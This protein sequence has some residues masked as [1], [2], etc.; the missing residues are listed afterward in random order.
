MI[1]ISS[2]TDPYQ[3]LEERN[4]VTRRSLEVLLKMGRKKFKVL[5][6]TKSN[7]VKRDIDL[8]REIKVAVTVTITTM[9]QELAKKLEPFAPP[10]YKRIEALKELK[11]NSIPTAVRLDPVIPFLTDSVENLE[12][13]VK[14]ASAAGVSQIISSTYKVKKDNFERMVKAF[15][16]LEKRWRKTYFVEGVKIKNYHYLNKQ[17]RRKIILTVK[18]LT[19]RYNV[20]FS[21]CREGFQDLQTA[22]TCDGSGLIK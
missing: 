13:V 17:L 14:E 6:V 20:K 15:P 5:I 18:K 9:N 4:Q 11:E 19:E 12:E 22:L 8:L 10:P 3:L 21:S 1:E 16:E 2:S 7:L